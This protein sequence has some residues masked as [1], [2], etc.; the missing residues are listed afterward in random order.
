MKISKKFVN[1]G[2]P[3]YQLSDLVIFTPN[4]DHGGVEK[5][6]FLLTNFL[7][8]KITNI[9]LVTFNS[10]DKKYFDKKINFIAQN[11]FKNY[12]NRIFKNL[13]CT[14]LLIK[15][16]LSG[17]KILILSFNS[18]LYATLL[19]K[20][21]RKKIIVRINASHKLWATNF[22]KKKIFKFFLKLPDEVIV[23]SVDLKKEINEEFKI[24]SRCIL[25]PFNKKEILKLKKNNLKLFNVDKKFF[26]I[27]F[28]GRLVDQ[29]DPFT[30]LKALKRIPK[31]FAIKALI[32]GSGYMKK[33]ILNYIKENSLEKRINQ[34]DFTPKAIQ[35]LNQCDLFVLTSKF[36]GLPNVL[37]EAQFLKK[38]I[39]SSNCPTGPREIL[40]GGRA[41]D[42]INI[43]KPEIFSKKIINYYLNK[44]RNIYK[45]KIQL[46]FE[47][48]YRYDFKTNCEKYFSLINKLS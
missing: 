48:L 13:V 45:R 22:L 37:L 36:E 21:F 19:A 31:K 44:K 26:K 47:N 43:N 11:I 41:G 25:N 17:K 15:I 6:L 42:L 16:V 32:I 9:S 35:Y 14:I 4:I 38:Y 12:K 7:S 27:L 28:L 40:L 23:N 24:K 30:F 34:I 33:N 1:N 29:K 20:I 8:K 18:N 10:S 39:I 3:K 5:N 46:G 2:K